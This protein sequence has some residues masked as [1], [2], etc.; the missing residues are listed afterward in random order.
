[1]NYKIH[2]GSNTELI[3]QRLFDHGYKWDIGNKD[4]IKNAA[5]LAFRK[6]IVYSISEKLEDFIIS[7]FYGE[8]IKELTLTEFFEMFPEQ[9]LSDKVRSKLQGKIDAETIKEICEMI[10]N[11]LDKQK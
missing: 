4:I 8:D 5:Y 1:M 2:A 9:S 10:D 11:Y 6:N 3:Q 7:S